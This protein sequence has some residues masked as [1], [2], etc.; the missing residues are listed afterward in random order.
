ALL[1][2]GGRLGMLVPSGLHSDLGSAPLRRALLEQHGWEWLYGFENRRGLFTGID[3]RCKFDAIVATRDGGPRTLQAS[4]MNRDAAACA[5]T[6]HGMLAIGQRT[7]RR[8]SPDTLAVPEVRKPRDLDLLERLYAHNVR[9]GAWNV[10]F[11]R[12]LDLTADAHRFVARDRA[13]ADGYARDRHGRW[14]RG[15]SALL[16]LWEGRM[17]GAFDFS[18]K[19]WVAGHGRRAQWRAIDHPKT[20]EPQYLVRAEELAE[21]DPRFREPKVGFMAV[22]SATNAR[23]MRATLLL[24]A[25]CGNSV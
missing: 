16:P 23:T 3:E 2:P 14:V 17:V 6:E 5:R 8:L 4:F 24:R 22:G 12:E 19:G 10:A 1:R 20:I 21:I 9:F 13:E 11:R 18:E 25:P 7:L 15:R